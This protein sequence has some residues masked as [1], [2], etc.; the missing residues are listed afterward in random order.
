MNVRGHY[1]EEFG[2]ESIPP[3]VSG[4]VGTVSRPAS[5]RKPAKHGEYSRRYRRS[6]RVHLEMPV[7]VYGH[8]SGKEPFSEEARTLIVNAHGA[9]IALTHTV[10]A[11]VRLILTNPKTC[12]EVE[13]R[14]VSQGP[15]ENGG[16]EVAIEFIRPSPRFWGIAFPPEDWDPAE[17][18]RPQSCPASTRSVVRKYSHHPPIQNGP[19]ALEVP[20]KTT[21][22]LSECPFE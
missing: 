3:V 4:R 7:L 5:S 8:A 9:L 22:T 13:C 20:S 15:I 11:E 19:S 12:Q 17:R 16:G 6:Q 2:A 14:V 18:K 21:G 10:N 1:S